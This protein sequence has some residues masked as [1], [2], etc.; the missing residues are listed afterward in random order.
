MPPQ[1]LA[2]EGS[3]LVPLLRCDEEFRHVGRPFVYGVARLLAAHGSIGL[4]A[5]GIRDPT[6]TRKCCSSSPAGFPVRGSVNSLWFVIYRCWFVVLHSWQSSPSRPRVG[7]L[8]SVPCN[9]RLILRDHRRGRHR[10]RR[11]RVPLALP[12]LRPS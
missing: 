9:L 4:G 7:H 2:L 1:S 5:P 6:S 11:R 10:E 8:A 12:L 3:S